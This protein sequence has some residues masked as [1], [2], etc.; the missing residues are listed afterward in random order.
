VPNKFYTSNENQGTKQFNNKRKMSNINP[1][2]Q[3][4]NR[5]LYKAYALEKKNPKGL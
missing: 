2:F 5:K 3:S 4:K 1:K